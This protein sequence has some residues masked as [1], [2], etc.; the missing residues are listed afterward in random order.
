[1]KTAMPFAVDD[2]KIEP[3]SEMRRDHD[4]APAPGRR[5]ALDAAVG[6]PVARDA[7][8]QDRRRR[9]RAATY[10]AHTAAAP[11]KRPSRRLVLPTGPDH[12]RL[13]QSALG[14]AA[15]GAEREE[16]GEHGAQE[17]DREHGE[18]EQRGAGQDPVVELVVGAASEFDLVE[19]DRAAE[20]VQRQEADGQEQ[21]DQDHPP[22]H[23]LAER[24]AG[25]DQ[26]AAHAAPTASR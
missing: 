3:S 24:V 16:H 25:D 5:P 22:P 23:R 17:E 12:E 1:M 14:V 11:A 13:E 7:R 21:H 8:D 15:N 4:H 2:R 18:A 19:R 10:S 6:P 26:R 20:P 9:R